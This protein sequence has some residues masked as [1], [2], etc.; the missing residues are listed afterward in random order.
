MQLR[1]PLRPQRM[2]LVSAREPHALS[3]FLEDS[4]FAPER[5]AQQLQFGRHRAAFGQRLLV[6]ALGQRRDAAAP[7]ALELPGF[8]RGELLFDRGGFVRR[9]TCFEQRR[10]CDVVIRARCRGPNI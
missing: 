4:E 3:D 8:E 7:R 1:H 5:F 6:P 2:P 10:K 9:T